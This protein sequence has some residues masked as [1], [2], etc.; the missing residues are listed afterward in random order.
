MSPGSVVEGTVSAHR[1]G[2]GFLRVE[3]VSESVFLPPRQMRGIMHGDRARVRVSQDSS[4]RWLGDVLEV[5]GR[6]VSAFLGTV[7]IHGRAGWSP[8]PIA[9]CS[10]GARWRRRI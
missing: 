9:V 5:V 2:Y 7:E 4:D 1:A 10:C 3:G 6:G 8:P